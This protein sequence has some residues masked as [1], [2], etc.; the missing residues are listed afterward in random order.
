LWILYSL[1]LLVA[2]TLSAPWWLLR[3]ATTGRYRAGLPQRLGFIPRAVRQL[4]QRRPTL[5]L[6]AVSV[7]EL[8]AAASLIRELESALPNHVLFIS[9][10]TRT[11]NE[12]AVQRYGR[13]RTF[14]MPLDFAWIVNRYLNA[15]RP[16][17]LVLLETELWPNLILQ[18]SRRNTPIAVVNARISDRSFPRYRALRP[19]LAPLLRRISLFCAQSELDATRLRAIG[20]PSDRVSVTGNLKY[21][22]RATSD[23][24]LAAELRR[25]L[26]P[27]TQLLVFGSTLDGEE[28]LALDA[29]AALLPKHPNLTLLLAPRHPERAAAVAQ[30]IALRNT[31]CIRRTAWSY[32]PIPAG[33]VLLLDTVGE[34]ASLYALAAVA[35]VGGSLVPAGGHNPL[36]PAHFA[37]PIVM[38]PSVHNFRAI[39]DSLRAAD[40]IRIVEKDGLTATLDGLL[41]DPSTAAALGAN[42]SRVFLHENGAT[43][44]ALSMLLPMLLPPIARGNPR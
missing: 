40:A 43:S 24:A 21:D 34:L 17:M 26:A 4:A 13:D 28:Q 18:T 5:W 8:I 39:V 9:T 20:A 23:S 38:G 36:E 22:V 1:A 10:T 27:A 2:L 16:Q 6:H 12:L 37:V 19:L 41:S 11:G 29:F 31:P 30:H 32:T 3:M 14:Y 25:C 15:L 33:S 35:F 7:G 44:R 42:A